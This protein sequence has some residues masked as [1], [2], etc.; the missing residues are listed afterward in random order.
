MAVRK[1]DE[2]LVETKLDSFIKP[3]FKTGTAAEAS[4]GDLNVLSFIAFKINALFRYFCCLFSSALLT[5]LNFPFA[6]VP[7]FVF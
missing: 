4:V 6:C 1:A 7:S 2:P 5:S 3:A